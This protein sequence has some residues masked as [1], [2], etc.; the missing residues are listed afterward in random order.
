MIEVY[1]LIY[2]HNNAPS[3]CK[4]L[5]MD[6]LISE[7][8]WAVN[9]HN[10][11]SDIKLVYLYSNIKMMHSPISCFFQFSQLSSSKPKN[12]KLSVSFMML[13]YLK[14]MCSSLLFLEI[15]FITFVLYMCVNISFFA[16]YT[17]L[18]HVV[19]CVLFWDIE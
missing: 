10:K 16:G 14:W 3:S 7:T 19:H 8:C 12:F 17:W 13:E 11:A 5:R 9:W 15:N 4:L 6:V 1:V 18:V 2:L